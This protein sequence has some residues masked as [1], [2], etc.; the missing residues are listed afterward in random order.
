MG[1]VE[2]VATRS[3][4][5]SIGKRESLTLGENQELSSASEKR[6]PWSLR[7]DRLSVRTRM[8]LKR[9]SAEVR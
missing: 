6:A 8:L 3:P 9:F 4:I 5:V 2:Y 7:T 1:E